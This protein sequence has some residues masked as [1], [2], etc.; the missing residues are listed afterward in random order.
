MSVNCAY[1]ID[2]FSLPQVNVGYKHKEKCRTTEQRDSH[3]HTKSPKRT[4]TQQTAQEATTCNLR[5]ILPK[6]NAVVAGTNRQRQRPE[7]QSVHPRA[8]PG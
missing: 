6:T 4:E 8:A 1:G 3:K 5:L 7:S 2:I